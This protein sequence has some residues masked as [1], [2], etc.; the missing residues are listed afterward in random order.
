MGP[1]RLPATL[2]ATLLGQDRWPAALLAS[3]AVR[4]SLS[5]PTR[6]NRALP[7][8]KD[9]GRC[10]PRLLGSQGDRDSACMP[11]L[12]LAVCVCADPASATRS[13]SSRPCTSVVARLQTEVVEVFC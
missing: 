7:R 5:T 11:G 2:P 8:R 6:E 9:Q 3:A 1:L 13:I 10:A 4:P 12:H